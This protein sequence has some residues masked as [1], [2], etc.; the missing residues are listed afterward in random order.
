MTARD[1]GDFIVGDEFWPRNPRH[2]VPRAYHHLVRLWSRCRAGMGGMAV[3]P[4]AG[5][6]NAQ[7]AW[8]VAAFGV[9]DG[10]DH[11]LDEIDKPEGAR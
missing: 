6:L 8:L 10:A 4:E 1:G 11:R 2:I 7:P 3:L 5:G 9:L